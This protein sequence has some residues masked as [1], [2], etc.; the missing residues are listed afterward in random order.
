MTEEEREAEGAE[1]A[2]EDLEAPV[3]AQGDV[4]GGAKGCGSPS[5]VCTEPTCTQTDA[6]CRQLSH[7]I[8]VYDR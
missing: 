8:V 3:A 2:I 5:L 1:E 7:K 6:K 4:A